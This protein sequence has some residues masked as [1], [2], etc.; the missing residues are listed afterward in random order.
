MERKKLLSLYLNR[1]NKVKNR[2]KTLRETENAIRA[3]MNSPYQSSYS[4]DAKVQSSSSADKLPCFLIRI[5]EINERIYTQQLQASRVVVEIMNILDFLPSESDE[6]NI[7]EMKYI[8]KK[9][10]KAIYSSMYISKSQFYKLRNRAFEKLLRYAK[11]NEILDLYERELD[12]AAKLC[13]EKS[14]A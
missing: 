9:S 8:Q 1:Y 14:S 2:I 5:E 13:K 6:R 11:V 3:D 12:N 10:D 4:K 7:L